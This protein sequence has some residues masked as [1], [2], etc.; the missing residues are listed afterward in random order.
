LRQAVQGI[1]DLVLVPGLINLDFADIR[2]IM[3][4]AGR[5]V[6]GMGTG[7]GSGGA[8]EAARKSILNPLLEKSS[9]EGAKGILINITGGLNISLDEIQEAASLIHDNS[10]E[11]ANII[12]GAVIDPSMKDD[13][14][15]TVIAT[16]ID[17][18][19]ENLDLPETKVWKPKVET[20]PLRGTSSILSKNVDM[21]SE[22]IT[23]GAEERQDEKAEAWPSETVRMQPPV[24]QP[25][26]E[27]EELIEKIREQPPVIRPEPQIAG[28]DIQAD[29]A[30]NEQLS[31]YDK[32]KPD[33]SVSAI[34]AEDQYD[35][36]T[37]LRKRI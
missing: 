10:H 25:A 2:S 6:I 34:P 3:Q 14:R 17:E 19:Q 5:A 20:T 22:R 23:L 36:P 31:A 21:V 24:I 12:L 30:E 7:S 13:I 1:S 37:F 35:I 33:M 28:A 16:G 8:F 29:P 4:R 26:A 18:R 32:L 11:D 9:I 27:K 15:V